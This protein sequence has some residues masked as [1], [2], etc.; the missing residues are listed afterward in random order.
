MQC[1]MTDSSSR[2]EIVFRR[3]NQARRMSDICKRED[4]VED[5]IFLRYINVT[6]KGILR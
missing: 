6:V 4:L 3:S 1:L 2:D 5:V